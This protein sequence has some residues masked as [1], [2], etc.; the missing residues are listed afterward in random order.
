[1][2]P[3]RDHHARSHARHARSE[4]PPRHA[5]IDARLSYANRAPGHVREVWSTVRFTALV[6]AA[7]VSLACGEHGSTRPAPAHSG[8][9]RAQPDIAQ[10]V[11]TTLA[12]EPEHAPPAPSTATTD[13]RTDDA[14]FRAVSERSYSTFAEACRATGCAECTVA[15]DGAAPIAICADGPGAV[16]ANPYRQPIFAASPECHSSVAAACSALRCPQRIPFRCQEIFD[17][18]RLVECQNAW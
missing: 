4:V 13:A 10:D 14:C 11:D 16:Y 5:R 7:L 17:T 12:P 18:P 1:M 3:K 15:R 6:L 9:E 2:N 8:A